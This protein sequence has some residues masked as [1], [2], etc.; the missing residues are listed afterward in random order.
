M[1]SVL[2]PV[3][4]EAPAGQFLLELV[5][6]QR[7]GLNSTL[8]HQAVVVFDLHLAHG[9]WNLNWNSDLDSDSDS[10]ASRQRWLG[11]AISVLR[12]SMLGRSAFEADTAVAGQSTVDMDKNTTDWARVRATRENGGME[13]YGEVC[14][15]AHDFCRY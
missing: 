5:L 1:H 3:D 4:P 15:P 13:R 7:Y 2:R 12:P 14:T 6:V 8:Q 9:L 10:E 11:K